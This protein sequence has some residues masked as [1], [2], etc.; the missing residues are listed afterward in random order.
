MS[1][2]GNRSV[3]ATPPHEIRNQEERPWKN[4]KQRHTSNHLTTGRNQLDRY[5][6]EHEQRSISVDATTGR[7][8]QKVERKGKKKIE[9]DKRDVDDSRYT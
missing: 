4:F 9:V 1:L 5:I 2:H 3:V 8:T 7:Q 6:P